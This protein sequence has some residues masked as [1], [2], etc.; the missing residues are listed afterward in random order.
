MKRRQLIKN[1]ILSNTLNR[2]QIIGNN[3]DR[4]VSIEPSPRIYPIN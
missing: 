4:I 3:T 1:I 2:P